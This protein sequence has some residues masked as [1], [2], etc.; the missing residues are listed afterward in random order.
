MGELG[1]NNYYEYQLDV[2]AANSMTSETCGL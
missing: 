1:V 2:E